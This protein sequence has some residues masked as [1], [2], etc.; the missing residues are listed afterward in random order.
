MT[1]T[2]GAHGRE[3]AMIAV[4]NP[5]R[6]RAASAGTSIRCVARKTCQGLRD[7][8]MPTIAETRKVVVRYDTAA[9]AGMAHRSAGISE[10]VSSCGRPAYRTVAPA[11]VAIIVCAALKMVS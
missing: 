10:T 2:S 9:A 11:A 5:I 4:T 1:M 6:Y 7:V 8:W 3:I